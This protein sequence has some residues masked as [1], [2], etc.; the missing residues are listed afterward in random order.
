MNGWRKLLLAVEFV[1]VADEPVISGAIFSAE[2]VEGDS[3]Q[4]P[5][6]F[7]VACKWTKK[8]PF[9]KPSGFS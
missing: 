8:V 4:F 6:V 7:E 3:N 9:G 2:D 5:S 1:V